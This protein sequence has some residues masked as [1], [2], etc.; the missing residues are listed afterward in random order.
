M[1]YNLEPLI[2]VTS[3][4]YSSSLDQDTVSLTSTLD[5]LAVFM[6]LTSLDLTLLCAALRLIPILKDSIFS[7][8]LVGQLFY[9]FTNVLL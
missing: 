6:T 2:E 3:L 1:S 7:V 4:F 8:I 5:F 9:W